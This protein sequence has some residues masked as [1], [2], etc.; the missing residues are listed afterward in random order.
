[1][2][3]LSPIKITDLAAQKLD[4]LL[5]AKGNEQSKLRIFIE[6]GGCSGFKYGFV[7]DKV[8]NDDDTVIS[9]MLVIDCMSIQFLQG[10]TLDYKESLQEAGFVIKNPQAKTTCGCG[11]SFSIE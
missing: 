4:V 5:L 10:A 2:E 6:G 3:L 11:S 1:M 7:L 8:Q 9:N